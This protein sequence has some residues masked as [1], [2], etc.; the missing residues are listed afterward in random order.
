[1]QKDHIAVSFRR[2]DAFDAAPQLGQAT[3]F[4][5][6]GTGR[7]RLQQRIETARVGCAGVRCIHVLPL[8]EHRDETQHAAA[9]SR[10]RIG[11]VRDP[12][13]TLPI[14]APPQRHDFRGLLAACNAVVLTLLHQFIHPALAATERASLDGASLF[15]GLVIYSRI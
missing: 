9:Q 4:R 6:F 2:P 15:H 5:T 12:L 10:K 14:L 3:K 11:H 7:E 8:V 13:R 1:M